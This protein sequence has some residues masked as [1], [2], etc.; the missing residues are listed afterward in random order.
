M[1]FK[2]GIIGGTGLEDPNI[3]E[4]SREVVV[5]T[6]FGKPSD[7]LLE[8]EVD[9]VPCVLLSRHGRKHGV[10]PTSVNFRA[11]LWALM[12]QGVSVILATATSGSLKEEITPGSLVFLDSFIDR[13]FK[14]EIT[15]HDGREGNPAKGVCHIPSHPAYNEKLRQ[16]SSEFVFLINNLFILLILISCAEQLK[17]KYFKSGTV[18]CIE[19][20]RYSSKAE[21]NVFRSWN[22]DVIN[23]TVCPEVYL[24]KELGIPFATTAIITDYDCWREGDEVS[25][26]LVA[27]RMV[28]NAYKAKNL[29]LLAIKKI[30][31]Q[32]WTEEIKQAKI[33]ARN[34]VMLDKDVLIEHLTVPQ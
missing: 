8:G 3:F 9:G 19:G 6:P 14:R 15:F 31:E 16:A 12:Q 27:E 20:P 17:Y 29:F 5:E 2:I 33:V 22:A 18:V 1:L 4:N 30:K 21:S 23:M 11:N 7:A 26:E 25:V 13:T 34:A 28:E 32:D 10:P 24:A